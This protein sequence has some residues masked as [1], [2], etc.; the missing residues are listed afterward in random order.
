MSET[1]T[2]DKHLNYTVLTF[3]QHAEDTETNILQKPQFSMHFLSLYYISL[4][5]SAG[6]SRSLSL[7]LNPESG[8]A[9]KNR[10]DAHSDLISPGLRAVHESNIQLQSD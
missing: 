9:A 5:L 3:K 10:L 6:F 1:N 8:K 7:S 4:C 2:P